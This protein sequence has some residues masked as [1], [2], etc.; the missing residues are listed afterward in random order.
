VT[1]KREED[2]GGIALYPN[3]LF[4]IFCIVVLVTEIVVV[5]ALAFPP[6]VRRQVNLAFQ[7]S[8]KPAWYF[9][10]LYELVKYFPGNLLFL[11]A[12]VIPLLLLLLLYAV[13]WI[14]KGPETAIRRRPL[15]ALAALTLTL[16][17]LFL[18]WQGWR[19]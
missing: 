2:R 14:D 5:L 1:G 15:P 7:F 3:L 10:P 19:I 18:L 13:P 16:A 11:G 4:E 9:L 6:P 17:V 8:P 12:S